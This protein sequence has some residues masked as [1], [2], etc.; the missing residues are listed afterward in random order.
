MI[1]S[2]RVKCMPLGDRV[3]CK[4]L[5]MIC[6]Q[7]KGWW[8]KMMILVLATCGLLAILFPVMMSIAI[9]DKSDIPSLP[10]AVAKVSIYDRLEEAFSSKPFS[11]AILMIVMTM[12]VISTAGV[13]LF[14]AYSWSD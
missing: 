5:I 8:V 14:G 1:G 10:K 4:R 3:G 13:V 12:L 6:N 7:D 9:V 2:L 11:I